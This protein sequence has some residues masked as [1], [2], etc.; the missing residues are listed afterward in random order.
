MTD[1]VV[2][3][4]EIGRPL[5]DLLKLRNFRTV[6]YDPNIPEFEGTPLEEKYDMIH[7]CIPYISE[8]QFDGVVKPY[9]YLTDNVVIH[10]TVAKGTSKR[11]GCIYSPV[12]GVHHDM[13][14]C[15][16]WFAK[17][18]SGSENMEF[19]K[20]FPNS[21]NVPDSDKLEVTKHVAVAMYSAFMAVQRHFEEKH[22]YYKQFMFELD[23][24]YHNLPTYYNDEKKFGGHCIGPNIDFLD[25]EF[26]NFIVA[27][28]K[29]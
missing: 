25:D 28:Y 3:L 22:P 2:G 8:S 10:S 1:L 20:R 7:I 16:Q 9:T 24:R 26:V 11:L 13:L 6:G 19:Q 15:L 21:V 17:Y 14:N 12:R 4:G 29:P 23:Q 18:Y 5:Y 27:K